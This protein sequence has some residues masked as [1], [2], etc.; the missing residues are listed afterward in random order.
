V[1]KEKLSTVKAERARGSARLR[2]KATHAQWDEFDM[3]DVGSTIEFT[4]ELIADHLG[5]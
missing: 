2:A 1:K 3:K 5:A 4:R